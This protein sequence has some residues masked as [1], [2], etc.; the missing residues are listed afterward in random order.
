MAQP[1]LSFSGPANRQVYLVLIEMHSTRHLKLPVCG[2]GRCVS[3]YAV[4]DPGQLAT[5]QR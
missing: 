1:A 2:E 4:A 3:L 5:S